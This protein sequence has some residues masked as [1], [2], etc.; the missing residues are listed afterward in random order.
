MLY[1]GSM[2]HPVPRGCPLLFLDILDTPG[3]GNVMTALKF[4]FF[5]VCDHF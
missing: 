1:D 2:M 3:Q 5:F 4:L